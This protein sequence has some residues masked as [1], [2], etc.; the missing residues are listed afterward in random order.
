MNDVSIYVPVDGPV[1]RWHPHTKFSLV[2]VA[3]LLAAVPWYRG[4]YWLL[5]PPAVTLLLAVLAALDGREILA[6]WARR[7]FLLMAP[8]VVSLVL[9]NG[10]FW[11]GA[12][13]VIWR[14]GPLTLTREGLVAAAVFGGRLFVVL[15]A[16]LLLLLTTHPAD[17]VI[18]LQQLGLSRRIAYILISVLHLLPRMQGRARTI[19]AAQ[20]SR[21]LA[22]EGGLFQRA[23]AMVPLLAPLV[24]SA[25]G[26]VEERAMALEARAFQAPT[27]K[28]SLRTL[29]DSTAQQVARWVLVLAGLA[30]LVFTRWGL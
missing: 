9:V 7:L 19:L 28:T 26:D 8:F 15:G 22:L 20:Q 21:G 25:I 2:L 4:P 12:Q 10:F 13:D 5:G 30:V 17:L 1:H 27:P 23:R 14:I 11:P 24:L 29:S 3:L 6:I 18:G 16:V